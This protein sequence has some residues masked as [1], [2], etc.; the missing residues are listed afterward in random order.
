[1][2]TSTRLSASDFTFWRPTASGDQQIDFATFSPDYHPQDRIGVVSP[3][4]EAG[5]LHTSYALLA[6]TTAFYDCLRARRV[7]FFDYPQHFAFVGIQE[8]NEGKNGVKGEAT[9]G[10]TM[11]YAGVY[12]GSE[13][14]P[15][16]TPQLWN[17]WSWLDVWPDAKWV[18]AEATASAL[19]QRAFDYQINRLFWPRSLKIS[20]GESQLPAHLWRMLNTSLKAVYLYGEGDS[21]FVNSEGDSETDALGGEHFEIRVLAAA[22]EI[23]Q[24]SVV[25]L[26]APLL[27]TSAPVITQAPTT[28]QQYQRVDVQAFLAAL[29]NP[30]PALPVWGGS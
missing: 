13:L 1:M 11:V 5:V 6:F 10:A 18:T 2:H 15:L 25:Q 4:L 26:P 20:A 27:I 3:A 14:L 12:A 22:Q 30:T 24:E 28:P 21:P 7:E 19:L 29:Q 8:K 23:V 9:G 17:A 16:N